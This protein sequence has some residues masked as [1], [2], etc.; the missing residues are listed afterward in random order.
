[1]IMERLMILGLVLLTGLLSLLFGTKKPKYQGMA[2]CMENPFLH[3]FMYALAIFMI[4]F[5][6]FIAAI[7]ST[8][9]SA[10]K[11]AGG[12]IVEVFSLMFLLTVFLIALGVL[13]GKH[14]V[15]YDQEK[16]ILGRVFGRDLTLAWY[17]IG[18]VRANRNGRRIRLY[19][20]EGKRVLNAHGLMTNYDQFSH[21]VIRNLGSRVMYE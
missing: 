10:W 19:D 11:E 16:L 7:V 6:V 8:D 20:R 1:M 21:I 9:E 18:E 15:Y 13:M 4:A 17:E 5:A 14:Y 12:R 2:Q 3:F